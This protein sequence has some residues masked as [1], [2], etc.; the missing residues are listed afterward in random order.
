M[1][2][3]LGLKLLTENH[4]GI[5]EE[6]SCIVTLLIAMIKLKKP[7]HHCCSH[8]QSHLV[9][10]CYDRGILM[11]N[12]LF[13]LPRRVSELVRQTDFIIHLSCSC[14]FKDRLEPCITEHGLR[15]RTN[16]HTF[17]LW[18][19]SH[20]ITL[21]EWLSKY[22]SEPSDYFECFVN[23]TVL[24]AFSWHNSSPGAGGKKGAKIGLGGVPFFDRYPKPHTATSVPHFHLQS[25]LDQSL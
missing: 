9:L 16:S 22:N 21:G 8:I 13:L 6:S 5:R 11:E 15:E 2:R 7:Q 24:S 18:L 14:E 1:L 17:V 25:D 12:G 20:K 23:H 19:F 4:K 10:A 3:Y